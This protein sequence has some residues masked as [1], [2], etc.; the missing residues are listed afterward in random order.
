L[1][2]VFRE[3]R[4]GRSTPAVVPVVEMAVVPKLGNVGVLEQLLEIGNALSSCADDGHVQLL[5]GRG[6][7]RPTQNPAWDD[8]GCHDRRTQAQESAPSW[9]LLDLHRQQASWRAW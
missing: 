2:L 5:A 7:A 1:T 9:S 3:S 4:L 6:P 8:T